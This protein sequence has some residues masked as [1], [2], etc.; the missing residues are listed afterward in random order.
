MKR[1]IRGPDEAQIHLR[2]QLYLTTV[3]GIYIVGRAIDD[4]DGECHPFF[5]AVEI[6]GIGQIGDNGSDGPE[7]FGHGY[8]QFVRHVPT[9]RCTN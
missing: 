4:Q 3:V 9:P 2:P 5:R 7:A 1:T 6:V 8:G